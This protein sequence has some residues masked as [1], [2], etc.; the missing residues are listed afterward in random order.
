MDAAQTHVGEGLAPPEAVEIAVLG[1][2]EGSK[3]GGV[4]SGEG[5]VSA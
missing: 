4:S 5:V 1:I 3:G 2:I